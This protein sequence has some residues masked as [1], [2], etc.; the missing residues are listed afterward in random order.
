M[1]RFL[2]R[3]ARVLA[4]SLAAVGAAAQARVLTLSRQAETSAIVRDAV[5][6]GVTPGT[7]SGAPGR[8]LVEVGAI[9]GDPVHD[10]L[11]VGVQPDPADSAAG[12]PVAL[13]V[14]AYGEFGVPSGSVVAD[15]GWYFAALAFD[16][17]SS[18]LVGA[19]ADRT[20]LASPRLF[21]IATHG[22]TALDAPVYVD[23]AAGCCRL[24]SGIATWKADSHD[25]LTIGR[26]DGDSEDQLLRF[27]FDGGSG[28]PDAYP[29]AGDRVV[30]LA[31]DPLDGQVYAL[32]RS[33]LDFTYLARI[34]WSTPG[35]PVTL[36]AIG[37]TPSACCYVG[38]GPAA[39]DGEG[40]ARALYAFTRDAS[41]PA[42]MQ[43]GAFAFASGAQAIAN[44]ASE[45][46]GL[47]A[48]AIAFSDRIFADGFDG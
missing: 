38:S 34:T 16:D 22:G 41:A 10:L 27:G 14:V 42:A 25:L 9:A 24:A 33:A 28:L 20:G 5:T 12:D 21:S 6:G 29:I 15:A 26:R 18:S 23:V 32:L 4:L 7:L 45:G 31:A 39:I 8:L 3:A 44:P 47:W 11:Y 1:S 48:D 37:S 2:V 30:A 46:Y 36:S 13:A 43:L 35:T 40:S 17:G 19:V